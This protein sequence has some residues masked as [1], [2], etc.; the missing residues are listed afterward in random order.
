VSEPV[1]ERECPF[2]GQFQLLHAAEG[3]YFHWSTNQRHC[4]EERLAH[5]DSAA[6]HKEL[7]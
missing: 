4:D 1:P 5:W 2:C 3:V 7:N 6:M